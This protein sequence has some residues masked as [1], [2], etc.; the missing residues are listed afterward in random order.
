MSRPCAQC[1]T[2]ATSL[3]MEEEEIGVC[4]CNFGDKI[5]LILIE[6]MSAVLSKLLLENYHLY[7][8]QHIL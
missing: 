2:A 8:S 7:L 4:F 1:V 5:L 6:V 3:L